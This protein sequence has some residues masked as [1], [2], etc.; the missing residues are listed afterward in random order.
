MRITHA[1]LMA[2]TALAFLAGCDA[3]GD[4]TV[5]GGAAGPVGVP[6]E[7]IISEVPLGDVAGVTPNRLASTIDNPYTGN[8][9]AIQE[10]KQLFR[11]M[12]CADC[13][14]YTAKGG[15]GPDLTD[16]SWR[17]GGAPVNVF[18]SIAEGRPKG[19]PAWGPALPE[20]E[21]WKIVAY[22]QTL[23]GTVPADSADQLMQGN[24]SG[25]NDAL[26]TPK[27]NHAENVP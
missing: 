19:M 5:R 26:R 7:G 11:Q 21:I 24:E 16:H 12:N 6:S 27:G 8:P 22:I 18:K 17:Y 14:G 3:R 2:G 4:K 23:G 15:M 1:L 9:Q 25:E 13:H 20:V 10:G